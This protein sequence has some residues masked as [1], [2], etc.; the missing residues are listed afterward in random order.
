MG[1]EWRDVIGYEGRYRVSNLG[2]VSGTKILSPQVNNAGYYV[3]H[4]YRD[5][6]RSIALVHRLVA[7]AFVLRPFG[8]SEVNHLDGVKLNNPASN[9]EWVTRIENVRH[10]I[11][12]GLVR[13]YK[14]G[15]VGTCPL[16][17]DQIA[18]PSQAEAER[19]L[20][21]TGK[22]SSA[23]HH[24]LIGKKKSAYGYVWSRT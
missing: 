14:H 15:V 20:S 1:E 11:A 21:S 12:T 2:R 16:T 8:S 19:T 18:F 6:Q 23:I 17:G 5:G 24:C 13:Y 7:F 22:N 3:V 9:L 4:L 10:S